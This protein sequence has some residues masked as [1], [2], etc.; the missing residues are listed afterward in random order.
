LTA[1]FNLPADSNAAVV[2]V[3][4]TVLDERA[5][6]SEPSALQVTDRTLLAARAAG[7]CVAN[8]VVI[9]SYVGVHIDKALSG[10]AFA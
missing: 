9:T 6:I 2:R 1:H 4:A 7:R 3:T 5:R 10:N 8:A